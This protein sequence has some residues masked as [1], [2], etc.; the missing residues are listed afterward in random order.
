MKRIPP[1][2]A[3]F[4]YPVHEPTVLLDTDVKMKTSPTPGELAKPLES[5]AMPFCQFD[6]VRVCPTFA[7]SVHRIVPP[8]KYPATFCKSV[9]IELVVDP[10]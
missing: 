9:L 8:L 7:P 2:R 6:M 1:K 4:E 5:V 10:L 3:V